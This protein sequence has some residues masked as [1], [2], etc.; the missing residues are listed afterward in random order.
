MGGPL[1]LAVA[2]LVLLL[3][4]LD[5]GSSHA[6]ARPLLAAAIGVLLGCRVSYHLHM[7]KLDAYGGAYTDPA[8]FRR[9]RAKYI[10]MCVVY[11]AVGGY[12]AHLL[13]EL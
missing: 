12:L 6:A 10:G 11:G 8:K 4:P 1:L 7:R 9:A 13:A 3:I 5:P 2:L